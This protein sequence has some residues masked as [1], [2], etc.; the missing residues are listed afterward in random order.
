MIL[1]NEEP[2]PRIYEEAPD[3]ELDLW[4]SIARLGVGGPLV[5]ALRIRVA[6]LR[7]IPATGGAILAPNHMSV[8]D[9]FVVS[10]GAA[11]RGRAT[12][13]M[14]LTELAAKPLRG[15]G[16]RRLGMIPIRRGLGDWEAIEHTA[17]TVRGGALAGIFPEGK[18]GD[19][20]DLLPG[21][22]GAARIALSAGAPIVPVGLW[23]TQDRWPRTGFKSSRPLRTTIGLVFGSPIS[24]IGDPRSRA[25]VRTLTDH[26]MAA[27]EELRTEARQLAA[28]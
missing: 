17:E 10:W 7:N 5:T 12:R 28:G 8:L 23:G 3:S 9:P 6:G 4:W 26:V 1:P 27:I 2:R 21:N 24:P 14:T 20:P 16:M 19:G 15:W 18:M 25:D 13:F 11:R 22:K